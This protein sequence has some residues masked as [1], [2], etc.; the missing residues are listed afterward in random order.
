M[1]DS[2]FDD[3]LASEPDRDSPPGPPRWVKALGIVLVVLILLV[4]VMLLT[5]GAGEHGPGRHS[6]GDDTPAEGT[7]G[8][9]PPAEGHTPPPGAGGHQPP[10]G[11]H[12]PP[13][14][15]EETP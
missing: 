6:G 5:G 11:G 4:G 8:Q 13:G 12:A 3:E 14:G 15:Q 1:P 2:D 7:G 9:S 10:A